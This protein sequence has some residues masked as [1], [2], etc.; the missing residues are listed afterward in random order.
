MLRGCPGD[1]IMTGPEC[2]ENSS[3]PRLDS[4]A[5]GGI[6][7]R[8]NRNQTMMI[9]CAAILL[10]PLVSCRSGKAQSAAPPPDASRPQLKS[11]AELAADRAERVRTGAVVVTEAPL[12][13]TRARPASPPPPP[14]EPI[15][16]NHDSIRGDILMVNNYTLTVSEVLYPLW[17][18]V[19]QTRANQTPQGFINLL[20][21]RITDQVRNDIGS[22]LIYEKAMAELPEQRVEMLDDAVQREINRRV[23]YRFGGSIARFENHLQQHGMTMEQ[24]R[25]LVKRQMMV[26]SYTQQMLM[27]QVNVR[28]DELLA[29]YRENLK[30]YSTEATRE[31]L[32]IAAPFDKF[33]PENVNW[34]SAT[35]AAQARAKL[36]AMR[37]IRA[38]HEALATR[39]FQDVAREFSRG[40]HAADGGSWGPIGQPLRAPYDK[41]SEKIFLFST[42]QYSEPI[43]TETG[44]YIAQCGTIT[45]A[46]QTP[47]ADVQDEIRGEL[48][49]ERFGQLAGKY[50]YH[51]AERATIT[52]LPGFIAG[53]VERAVEGWEAESVVE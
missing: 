45:P 39:D 20:Q 21:K 17:E 26:R 14:A 2:F 10:W 4:L 9:V 44:W 33:L 52:D 53:A 15:K 34:Q 43:Q 11:E 1:E 22:L 37:H 8:M 7:V 18:W 47:F 27:P 36:Q 13:E 29:Y 19:E 48:E 31:L 28:R 30:R 3:P 41:P 24:M 5:A 23:S 6:V 38:A 49:D 51:L 25:R 35:T 40:V 42:G 12:I 32:L 50:I 16:P 46:T